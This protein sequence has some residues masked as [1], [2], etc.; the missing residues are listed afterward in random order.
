MILGLDPATK[1]GY[2]VKDGP[3][4]TWDF[5]SKRDQ[6]PS[7]KLIR[8]KNSLTNIH[9]QHGLKIVAFEAAR[10]AGKRNQ[11]ALVVQSEMQ[12]IIKQFCDER[13]IPYRGYS[14]SE[15][16]KHATG[17]G[18][19]SKEDMIAAAKRKFIQINLVDDN[20]ADALWVLDLAIKEFEG[21]L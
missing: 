8:L 4:G 3:S 7:L 21:G 2:A 5:T 10:N 6:S 14:P 19:A 17:K 9:N 13:D 16:K 11:G 12:G 1:C 18:N 15:I 20:H